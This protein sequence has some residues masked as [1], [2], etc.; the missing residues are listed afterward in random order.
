MFRPQY[1]KINLGKSENSIATPKL[2]IEVVKGF[3]EEQIQNSISSQ[4]EKINTNEIYDCEIRNIQNDMKWTRYLN[5]Y[6]NNNLNLLI[7]DSTT[8]SGNV[9][10]IFKSAKRENDEFDKLLEKA[11]QT[12]FIDKPIQHKE[13]ISKQTDDAL[14]EDSKDINDLKGHSPE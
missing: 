2:I 4:F 9:D 13:E 3:S 5:Y 6:M 11:S 14:E 8:I 12:L 1:S 10:T 7:F